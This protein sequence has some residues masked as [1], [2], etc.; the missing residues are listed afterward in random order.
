MDTSVKTAIRPI[1]CQPWCA[2]GSGHTEADRLEEQNCHGVEHRVALSRREQVKRGRTGA[3][4]EWTESE[5]DDYFT[6]YS[7]KEFS[8][9]PAVFIGRGA[10]AGAMLTPSEAR[11]LAQELFI[12]SIIVDEVHEARSESPPA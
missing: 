8:A 2:D 10:W 7:T 11:M 1:K 9:D 4:E 5:E 12:A 3:M 6:V